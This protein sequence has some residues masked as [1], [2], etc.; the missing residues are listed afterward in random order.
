MAPFSF[1]RSQHCIFGKEA[2]ELDNGKNYRDVYV[3]S[4]GIPQYA[5]DRRRGAFL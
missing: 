4:N 1:D 2:R 5:H 3:L